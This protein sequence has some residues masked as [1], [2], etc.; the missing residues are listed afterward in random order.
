MATEPLTC[1]PRLQP[2][3]SPWSKTKKGSPGS[4]SKTSRPYRTSETCASMSIQSFSFQFDFYRQKKLIC[5]DHYYLAHAVKGLFGRLIEP[6]L[7]LLSCKEKIRQSS[8]TSLGPKAP[9]VVEIVENMSQRKDWLIHICINARGASNPYGTCPYG[10]RPET[11]PKYNGGANPI[12]RL[13]EYS[14]RMKWP[15]PVF[16]VKYENV[17]DQVW[18]TT[19]FWPLISWWV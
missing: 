7:H 19:K 17:L 8:V 1:P 6:S 16:T 11:D 13:A 4:R 10:A 18:P 15:E 9:Q 5:H 14:R 12:S 3:S 2:A